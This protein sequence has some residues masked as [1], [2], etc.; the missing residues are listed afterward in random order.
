MPSELQAGEHRDPMVPP[1][2]SAGHITRT[3]AK[4]VR[5]LKT[6]P[7]DTTAWLSIGS[8]GAGRIKYDNQVVT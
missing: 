8:Q 1:E 5:G 3:Q 4:F 7:S 2:P 6:V